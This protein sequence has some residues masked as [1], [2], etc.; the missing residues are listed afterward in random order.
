[1]DVHPQ[2][3]HPLKH[4]YPCAHLTSDVGRARARHVQEEVHAALRSEFGAAEDGLAR[5]HRITSDAAGRLVQAFGQMTSAVTALEGLLQTHEPTM[6]AELHGELRALQMMMATTSALATESLQFEDLHAQLLSEVEARLH[7]LVR[8]A[9][10][11][12]APRVNANGKVECP[13][14]GALDDIERTLQDGLDELHG[15]P[16]TVMQRSLDPGDIE[17]F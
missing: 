3:G 12:A 10:E 5:A 17:L 15:V 7:G 11:L 4:A 16:R 9:T 14:G 6:P 1:M 13:A 2:Q 8:L